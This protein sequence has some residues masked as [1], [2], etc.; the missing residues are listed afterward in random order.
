QHF[1]NSLR[2]LYLPLVPVVS[3]ALPKSHTGFTASSFS[4]VLS[5]FFLLSS[6]ILNA[7][8]YKYLFHVRP[9]RRLLQQPA[10]YGFC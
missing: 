1:Y 2:D 7:L 3:S 10:Y 5:V 6:P 8:M 4:Q 9:F